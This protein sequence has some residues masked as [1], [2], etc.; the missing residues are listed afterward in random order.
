VTKQAA[1]RALQEADDETVCSS[2]LAVTYRSEFEQRQDPCT[3]FR[4]ADTTFFQ[5]DCGYEYCEECIEETG[6]CAYQYSTD[7]YTPETV[8]LG[9]TYC[10][11]F[12]TGPQ[13]G[14]TTCFDFGQ[15]PGSEQGLFCQVLVDDQLCA[16]CVYVDCNGNVEIEFDCTNLG[17]GQAN[18]CT[19][20]DE[21][22]SLD[23]PMAG[24]RNDVLTFDSCYVADAATEPPAPSPVDTPEPTTAPPVTQ[25]P[26]TQASTQSPTNEPTTRQ[27][28][29]EPTV[30]PTASPVEAP[31]IGAPTTSAPVAEVSTTQP[32]AAAAP[33]VTTQ[34]TTVEPTPRPSSPTVA[35]VVIPTVSVLTSPTSPPTSSSSATKLSWMI[36]ALSLTVWWCL[37]GGLVCE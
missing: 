23:S 5:V 20:D 27:P 17:Y 30:S 32:T 36:L 8:Y 2:L 6:T 28:T 31:V 10:V 13:Q 7:I 16:S 18:V 15:D 33:V 14:Q 24:F 9:G 11:D 21:D 3:C 35:P 26:T 29:A 25:E 37:V 4:D 12:T 22:F 19:A 34:T 1:S